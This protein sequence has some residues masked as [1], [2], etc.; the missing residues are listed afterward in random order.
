MICEFSCVRLPARAHTHTHTFAHLAKWSRLHPH[1]WQDK[2]HKSLTVITAQW[3]RYVTWLRVS[4]LFIHQESHCLDCRAY[5]EESLF[6]SECVHIMFHI[7]EYPKCSLTHTVCVSSSW[8]PCSTT[9]NVGGRTVLERASPTASPVRPPAPY[10]S[11]TFL[12]W[13]TRIQSEER[14]KSTRPSSKAVCQIFFFINF[15]AKV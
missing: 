9:D 10:P 13:I 4:S 7:L 15:Q 8:W 5:L 12:T 14:S 2:S 11:T 1:C 3:K 6:I